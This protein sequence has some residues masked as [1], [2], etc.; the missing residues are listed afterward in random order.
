V[1][2]PTGG[3]AT[4]LVG[5]VATWQEHY[6]SATKLNSVKY[7]QQ[8]NAVN[9]TPTPSPSINKTKGENKMLKIFIKISIVVV[10]H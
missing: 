1:W 10:K 5:G 3:W 9:Q 2:N 6:L 8:R 7:R 4:V